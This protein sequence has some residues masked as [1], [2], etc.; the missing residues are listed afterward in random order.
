MNLSGVVAVVTGGTGTIGGEIAEQL[1]RA[2]AIAVLWDLDASTAERIVECDVSDQSSVEGAM[3]LTVERFGT[4]KIL[5]NVAGISGGLSQ[6]ASGVQVE[7]DWDRVLSPTS[8]WDAV[9]SI[10]VL[11]V[12]NTSRAFAKAFAQGASLTNGSIVNITS[13]SGGQIADPAL[14]AYSTSKAAVHMITRLSAADFGPLG[15][16]VNAIAPGFMETRMK[17]MPGTE[18]APA[19]P[20]AQDGTATRIATATPLGARNGKPSDIAEAV[21]AVLAAGFVTGQI[22][23]VDGGLTQRSLTRPA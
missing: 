5:V 14:A 15:I 23:T 17:P 19:Q 4:P 3:R 6:R 11:G 12:V 13:I 22:I 10:N 21:L 9:L 18:A 16:Q 20:T 7:E 1:E 2:G 8:S